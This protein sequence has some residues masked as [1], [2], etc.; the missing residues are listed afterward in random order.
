M[1]K[2]REKIT[3]EGSMNKTDSQEFKILTAIMFPF[4]WGSR[5]IPVGKLYMYNR[6]SVMCLPQGNKYIR[7]I[8]KP[9]N[10]LVLFDVNQLMG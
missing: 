8:G 9:A 2:F 6:L 1:L 3:F 7:V 10:I 5:R 4:C